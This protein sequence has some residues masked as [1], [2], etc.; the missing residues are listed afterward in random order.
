MRE[1]VMCKRIS[2]Y[3]RTEAMKQLKRFPPARRRGEKKKLSGR[4]KRGKRSR[5]GTDRGKEGDV[6]EG[7]EREEGREGARSTRGE[8]K[9]STLRQAGKRGEAREKRRG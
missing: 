6:R 2:A 4:E 3:R 7:G 1:I 8:G 5:E 9:A